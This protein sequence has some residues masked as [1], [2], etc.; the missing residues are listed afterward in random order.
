MDL[1]YEKYLKYKE[2]YLNL[3]NSLL[4]KGGENNFS[5]L[6][7]NILFPHEKVSLITFKTIFK[8]IEEK[9]QEENRELIKELKN[10]SGKFPDTIYEI[11]A[12]ADKK[13]YEE[14][15][16]YY[17]LDILDN[18]VG[19]SVI[20]LQEVNIS[21]LNM[22]KEKYE[23]TS[24]ILYN[25]EEDVLI[26]RDKNYSRE[27]YRVIIIPKDLY[28]IIKKCDLPLSLENKNAII[29]KNG[30]SVIIQ[31]IN[32]EEKIYKLIN[33]HFHYT[34][35]PEIINTFIPIIKEIIEY[36]EDN[37]G[38]IVVFGGDTNKSLTELTELTDLMSGFSF[39]T[40]QNESIPTFI[41][42]DTL[43]SS[44]DHILTSNL[45][46]KISII[47]ENHSK[48]ILYDI[49]IINDDIIRCLL[50]YKDL[51]E[52]SSWK[53]SIFNIN[54]ERANLLIDEL[55]SILSVNEN[56]ISDHNPIL[57]ESIQN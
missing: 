34:F 40:T 50:K 57:F 31:D 6:S 53:I 39:N 19:K 7:F 42:T 12:L 45:P 17:I 43:S 9:N 24:Y 1:Y 2:K 4:Q 37:K 16:I 51:I 8:L 5:L 28:R 29:K 46:G 36:N 56:Y 14:T 32:N 44:P 27:E 20:F 33:V 22:L 15:R 48:Q 25:D 47:T 30:V 3:K 49:N 55:C 54:S 35:T 11:I 23:S 13:R 38:D 41:K 10:T 21:T 52:Q 18:Y 26:L